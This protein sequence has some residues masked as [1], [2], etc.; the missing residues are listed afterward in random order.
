MITSEQKVH[1]TSRF[2]IPFVSNND[3]IPHLVEIDASNQSICYIYNN[4]VPSDRTAQA[5][6]KEFHDLMKDIFSEVLE[7][8][9]R[10]VL[11]E[12]QMHNITYTPEG[13]KT[14]TQFEQTIYLKI[15]LVIFYLTYETMKVTKGIR[16]EI[17][18]ESLTRFFCTL[19]S[20]VFLRQ[21]I[22]SPAWD[23]YATYYIK[24]AEQLSDGQQLLADIKQYELNQK[25]YANVKNMIQKDIELIFG[26]L[27]KGLKEV[28]LAI[29]VADP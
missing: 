29:E 28:Y 1:P 6:A 9:D 13:A 24:M 17:N 3:Y 7:P 27:K 2:Y 11:K 4:K 26:M 19:T 18:D 5:F 8:S 15:M 21:I 10:G 23:Q 20:L 14:M 16:L 12:C 22:E 25:K